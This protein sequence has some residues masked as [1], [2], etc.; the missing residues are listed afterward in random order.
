MAN[1]ANGEKKKKGETRNRQRETT[2]IAKGLTAAG[3]KLG[4]ID[5]DPV[6]G[7]VIYNVIDDCGE[8]RAVDGDHWGKFVRDEKAKRQDRH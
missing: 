7:H 3:V 2:R 6:S 4:T 5:F 8:K 1:E